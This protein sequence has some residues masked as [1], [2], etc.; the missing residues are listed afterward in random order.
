MFC[1]HVLRCNKGSKA[2]CNHPMRTTLPML[3][4]PGVLSSSS[5]KKIKRYFT[6]PVK[7]RAVFKAKN[8]ISYINTADY[9]LSQAAIFFAITIRYSIFYGEQILWIFNRPQKKPIRRSSRTCIFS[10][11]A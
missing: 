5:C 3:C 8:V 7:A 10:L 1:V 2:S 9:K 6:P 4:M 11:L